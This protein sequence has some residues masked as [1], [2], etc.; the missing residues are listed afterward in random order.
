MTKFY[1]SST[2]LP[3]KENTFIQYVMVPMHNNVCYSS[4]HAHIHIYLYTTNAQLF[5][6]LSIMIILIMNILYS[7]HPECILV[8]FYALNTYIFTYSYFLSDSLS[9]HILSFLL[10]S[11]FLYYLLTYLLLTT[12]KSYLSLCYYFVDVVLI[13]NFFFLIVH[14]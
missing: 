7:Y 3:I 5:S 14:C 4:T 6:F 12:F 8:L 11:L 10:L 1:N 13:V 2:H 9:F